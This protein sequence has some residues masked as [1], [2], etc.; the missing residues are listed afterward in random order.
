MGILDPKLDK[1]RT[2]ELLRKKGALKAILTF[3]GG[4]DEGSVQSIRLITGENDEGEDF[5]TWYCNGYGMEDDGKGG[6][7][8]VPMSEPAN[9]D[10]ELADLLEGPINETFGSWGG[11]ESTV[12]TLTWDVEAETCHMHYEQAEYK[13]HE[14][15][16]R[17]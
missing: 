7:R 12:G 16:V 14:A 15:V 5:P 2:F 1:E 4:H 10:E 6:Y 13:S 17:F 9:E 3:E 8:Y 11:Q